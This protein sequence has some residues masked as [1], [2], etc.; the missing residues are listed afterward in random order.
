[1]KTIKITIRTN[2]P[3]RLRG[4]VQSLAF[5]FCL[6]L[7]GHFLDS[8]AMEWLGFVVVVYTGLILVPLAILERDE[9]LSIDEARARIDQL[10][11]KC[12]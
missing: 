4:F 11:E 12:K 6:I 2:T 1:M 5:A 10:E 8:A 7:P 3:F 9:G